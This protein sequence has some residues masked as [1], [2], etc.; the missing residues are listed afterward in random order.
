MAKPFQ[1]GRGLGSLIP[2]KP[3]V[4]KNFWGAG[5]PASTPPSQA[6][7]SA[8]TGSDTVQQL[9]ISLLHPNPHQPREH[10]DHESLEELVSSI[11][12][13]GI[14]QPLIVT[15]RPDGQYDLVAGERRWRAAEIA[16]LATV[17]ALVR[18]LPD[19]ERLELALIENIQRQNLNPLEE[20][21]A[22]QQLQ[23]EFNLTQEEVARHVGKS[24]SQIA[25]IERLLTLPAEIQAALRDGTISFGHAKVLL[26]V[27]SAD[28]QLKLFRLITREGLPVR[29]AEARGRRVKVRGH[30]RQVVA[31]PELKTWAQELQSALGTRVSINS[32]AG[33]GAIQIAF[34]SL[35]ELAALVRRLVGRS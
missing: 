18:E 3:A 21:A 13:H 19:H 30:E 15:P 27:E 5:A 34:Y 29:L 4:G 9:P 8:F 24:R 14:L 31:S 1:L 6:V 20:A 35:E 33:R 28:E 7:P 25:N 2:G 23:H 12:A 22:Y 26:G 11:K 17:P 16:G 32:R 10:F